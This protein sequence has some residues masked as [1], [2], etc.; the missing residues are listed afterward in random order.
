MSPDNVLSN[1]QKQKQIMISEG[2]QLVKIMQALGQENID[3][4]Y[5]NSKESKSYCN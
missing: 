3:L 1:T 4:S 5:I 2:D